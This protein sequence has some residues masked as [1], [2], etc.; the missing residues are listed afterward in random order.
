VLLLRTEER[1]D[2]WH[3]G[4]RGEDRATTGDGNEGLGFKLQTGVGGKAGV[5]WWER[6]PAKRLVRA[7]RKITTLSHVLSFTWK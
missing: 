3:R 7:F 1:G 2:W 6:V 4:R 5:R